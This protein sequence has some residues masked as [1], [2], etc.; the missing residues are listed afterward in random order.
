MMSEECFVYGGEWER[1]LRGDRVNPV[2]DHKRHQLDVER[3]V[4]SI[5]CF[6]IAESLRGGG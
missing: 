5:R 3:K 2:G 1:S 4:A 6:H